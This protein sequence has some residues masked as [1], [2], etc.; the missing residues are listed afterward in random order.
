MQPALIML[1]FF[2]FLANITETVA[3]FGGSIV[4][5]TFGAHYYPVAQL[6]PVF[7]PINVL[8]SAYIVVRYRRHI[9][10]DELIKRTLPVTALGIICGFAL[11]ATWHDDRLKP[12]YGLFVICLS[13]FQVLRLARDKQALQR[14]IGKWTAIIWLF[15]GGLLQGL[16][17][18]GGPLVVFCTTRTLPDKLEFRSTMSTLWLILNSILVVSHLA[19]GTINLETLKLSATMLPA[20]AIG[21]VAGDWLHHRISQHNFRLATYILLCVAGFVLLFGS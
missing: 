18:C 13:V 2:V 6:V 3:G 12:L 20:L 10:R 17:S 14:P 9:R 5:I 8:L 7:I 4:A 19:L 15:S 11:F 1:F 21:V 16:F